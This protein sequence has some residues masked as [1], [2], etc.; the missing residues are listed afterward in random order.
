M[1]P[2]DFYAPIS[3]PSMYKLLNIYSEEDKNTQKKKETILTWLR[4]AHDRIAQGIR[5][6]RA[7]T[8]ETN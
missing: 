2:L 8:G 3:D 6:E 4:G 7:M 1:E 5:R